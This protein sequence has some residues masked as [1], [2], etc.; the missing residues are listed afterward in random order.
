M[1][2]LLFAKV[3]REYA[4]MTSLNEFCDESI[5]VDADV[6]VGEFVAIY[7]GHNED[8]NCPELVIYW[9]ILAWK[10]Q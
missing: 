8:Q 5:M 2:D 3:I 7:K 9:L 10:C 6:V 1:F 4:S